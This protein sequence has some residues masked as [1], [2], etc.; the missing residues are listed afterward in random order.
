MHTTNKRRHFV[1]SWRRQS[2]L[3]FELSLLPIIGACLVFINVKII[4]M[5]IDKH[6]QLFSN[7]INKARDET[8]LVM[9]VIFIVLDILVFVMIGLFF[10]HRLIGP[11]YKIKMMLDRINSGELNTRIHL[12]DK[13]H[14]YEIANAI[15]TNTESYEATIKQVNALLKEIRDQHDETNN[16]AVG[17]KL[18][19]IE[20]ILSKYRLS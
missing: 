3:I 16:D 10:S 19:C 1:V 17:E 14:F 12:R 15:N 2:K 18:Q 20:N 7:I 11:A 9:I 6:N 5:T 4:D 8:D 13:D